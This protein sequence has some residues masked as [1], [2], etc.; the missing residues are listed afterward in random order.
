MKKFLL[1]LTILITAF[2]AFSQDTTRTAKK[3]GPTGEE[4]ARRN[5]LKQA[6]INKANEIDKKFA[7]YSKDHLYVDL[8]A[9]NWDYHPNNGDS[10]WGEAGSTLKTKV[11]SRGINIGF[12]WDF[13]IKGSRVSIA[14]G[15]A[16]SGV[17][18]YERSALTDSA[19]TGISFKSLNYG[20]DTSV[21]VNKIS[22]QY[23]EIPIELRIRTNPDKFGQMWKVAIGFKAGVRVDVHTKEKLKDGS[24]TKVYVERRFGDFNQFRMGPTLRVGYSFFN[25]T[26]YYG[27]LNVFKANLGPTA[28]EFA[29]GISFTAL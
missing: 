22:L 24:T 29:F 11:Y 10:R 21:K 19:G 28:H 27:V 8:L 9:T 4:I 16:Y 13:R 6:R 5:E 17:N 15:I 3:T 12:N 1:V 26:A 20:T 18:I 2:S 23:V 14:P 25:I 7:K